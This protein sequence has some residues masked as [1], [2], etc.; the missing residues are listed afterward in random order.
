MG[1]ATSARR[2]G[3][4]VGVVTGTRAEFGLL[5]TVLRALGKCRTLEVKLIVTGMHLLRRFGYTID[6][7]RKLGYPV[8]ATVRMQTGRDYV[9]GEPAAVARGIAGLGKAFNDLNIDIVLVLGDRIEAFAAAAAAATGRRVL[10]H[11][12][13]GDRAVGDLDDLY[14]DAISRLAHLHLVAS[15][16]AARRLKRMGE[17]ASRIHRVG[18]PGLDD[19]RTFRDEDEASPAKTDRW[20]RRK[21]GPLAGRDYAVVIQHPI[22]RSEPDESG[23]MRNLFVALRSCGLCA[24]VLYPNSDPGHAGIMAEIER[25]RAR[26]DV[27]V[28][29]SMFRTEYLRLVSRSK[30]MAGNSSSGIIESVSL[31]VCAVNIGPRQEGRLRCG[32]N[33]IDA[34]ESR[35]AIIRAIRAALS[36]PRPNA[37]RCVYGDGRAGERIAHHLESLNIT[38]GLLRKRLAY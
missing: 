28:I 2:Q 9:A 33:V 32:P 16:D 12:H 14:R 18:A 20:L 21:L 26:D 30:L 37:R 10:A 7:I 17:P 31:G 22:G 25:Y 1:A 27:H 13:G 29:P 36:R 38:P 23:V 4:R 8:D 35:A 24:V 19:I 34:G 3:K 6:H 5:E 15:D 11:I